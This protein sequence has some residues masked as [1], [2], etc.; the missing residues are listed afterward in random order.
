[1]RLLKF[2]EFVV[3]SR[4]LLELPV[5]FSE[6]F[7]DKL[8]NMESIVANEF[9]RIYIKNYPYMSEYTLISLG[10]GEDTLKY[11]DSYKLDEYLKKKYHSV[12]NY[13]TK[14]HLEMY[15]K[16]RAIPE[17]LKQELFSLPRTEIKIGRFIN[18]FFPNTFTDKAIE[19]FVNEWKS[20]V[21]EVNFEIWSGSD[22]KK[23]Y[24]SNN[25]H[26]A[27]DSSN[28]LINSCMNDELHLVDF[29]TYCRDCKVVVLLDKENHIL[30]R[31]LLW[32]DTE[33]RKILDRVYYVY[34][35]DYYKFLRLANESG[36]YYKKRNISGG[37][38]FIQKNKEISLKSEV[39]IPD[40]FKFKDDG[41]PYM[42]TFYYAQ[43]ELAMNY[44]PDGRY[45]K[46]QDTE[47]GYEE[48]SGK[49]VPHF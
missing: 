41:F 16:D 3:E 48:H 12:E 34:D 6:E 19:T 31:A 37:S 27:E 15:F 2:V 35:K 20:T 26:F 43:G 9:K 13:D 14:N 24:K 30:G 33:G 39:R 21:D 10:D 8:D 5:F 45:L 7:K 36:W 11:L 1:M 29:Y 23:A 46:L 25:Y 18:K 22:I 40:A 4:K 42:D 49:D 47:G 28:P 44:E 38:P 17:N 32:E